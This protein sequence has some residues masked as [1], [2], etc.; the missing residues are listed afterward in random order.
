MPKIHD[1]A[2]TLMDSAGRPPKG[3][4]SPPPPS[5]GR[6]SAEEIPRGRV[7][8]HPLEVDTLLAIMERQRL[9]H[10]LQ[11]HQIELEMQNDELQQARAES[12][13]ALERYTRLYDFAPV[14]YF[15]LGREDGS[16][17]QLNFA[18]ARLLGAER[19]SLVGK[20]FGLFVEESD[21]SAFNL[22][23]AARGRGD[24]AKSRCE[25]A[26]GSPDHDGQRRLVRIEAVPDEPGEAFNA[27]VFDITEQRR[28]SEE[29]MR[30]SLELQQFAFIAAHCLRAPLHSLSGLARSLQQDCRGLLDPRAEQRVRQVATGVQRMQSLLQDILD[31]VQVD[32][33]GKVFQPADLDRV[34]GEVVET[35]DDTVRLSGATVTC[36]PLPTVT[37]DRIQLAQVLHNLIDNGIKFRSSEPPR[38]HV[39]ARR[40]GGQWL[41]SVRD[42]GI[43][44]AAKHCDSIFEIFKRLHTQEEYPGAGIGLA[45]GRRIVQRHGGRL[46]V[47]S[48]PGQ[49]STFHFTLPAPEEPER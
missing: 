44:I 42:N 33:R 5:A 28:A 11:V 32:S 24:C 15:T 2:E 10:E 37:G 48:T 43:G 26:L 19:G 39:S 25:I 16:I 36:D 21:R 41:V 9:V 31:Y 1:E 20:R 8:E 49:G 4:G 29:L 7:D 46:W 34:Y 30:S 22:F 40:Q 18:G 14:G 45:V 6:S 12:Q 35:L 38:V 13:A 23:L 17:R 47:E 27:V 3:R